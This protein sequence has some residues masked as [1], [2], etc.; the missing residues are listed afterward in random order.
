MNI[1]R[2]TIL[3]L[4]GWIIMGASAWSLPEV[5]FLMCG[6]GMVISLLACI[7]DDK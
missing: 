3:C 6:V 1:N 2:Y 7:L 4:A 5:K